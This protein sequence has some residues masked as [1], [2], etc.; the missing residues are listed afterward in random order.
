MG[1]NSKNSYLILVDGNCALCH[2]FVKWIIKNKKENADIRFSALQYVGLDSP[3][4]V[5]LI[6]NGLFYYQTDVLLELS[7]FLKL[8]ARI[9][10]QLLR[11][12]PKKIR[13]YF[14]KLI[15]RHR[16]RWFGK[17]PE[18]C[19]LEDNRISQIWLAEELIKKMILVQDAFSQK[20]TSKPS[21]SSGRKG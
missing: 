19:Y 16:Y 7:G 11:I 10:I 3:D 1:T 17:V 13:D 14:Y 2:G 5:V 9:W 12:I 20:G 8:K 21:K 15:A 4:S 6:K 18:K